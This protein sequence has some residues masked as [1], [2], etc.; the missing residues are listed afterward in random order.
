MSSPRAKGLNGSSIVR[1]FGESLRQ[2]REM[3]LNHTQKT[4]YVYWTVRHRTRWINWTNSMS[5]YEIFN[6]STCFECYYTHP[7]E[8]ATV[9]GW[10]ICAPACIRI[11]P[12]S[13]RTAPIHHYT[14]KQSNTPTYS[15]QLL[16]MSVIALETRWAIKNFHKVT[17]SWFNLFN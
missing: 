3:S 1:K 2:C 12:Y 8:L 15:R 10:K 9:C 16:R 6:C 4:T 7:Q 17:S 11:P 5:L 13:S 14:P